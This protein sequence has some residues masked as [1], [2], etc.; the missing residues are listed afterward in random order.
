MLDFTAPV[1]EDVLKKI[2]KNHDTNNDGLLSKQELR[3]A[4]KDLGSWFPGF[5]ATGGINHAD[6]NKDG[7]I[8]ENELEA[9][10]NY[11]LKLGYTLK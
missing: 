7:F 4:F 2:F 3:N 8:D 1:P 11:A 10:V 9:L 6:A 5:R